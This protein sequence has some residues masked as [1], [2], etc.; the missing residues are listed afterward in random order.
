PPLFQVLLVLQNT[1]M[2]AFELPGL[3]L[4]LMEVEDITT[5][6][7]L[8]LFLKETDTGIAGE[9]QYNADLFTSS[10]ITNLSTHFQNLLSSV[11][12]TPDARINTLKMLSDTEIEALKKAK[13]HKKVSKLAKFKAIKLQGRLG[14]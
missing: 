12:E 6:F 8:A 2:P 14:D 11:T 7:D 10:T 5:R 9:W 1:P 3:S 4:K 13:K